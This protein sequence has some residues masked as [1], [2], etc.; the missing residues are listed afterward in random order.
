MS[1]FV[2]LEKR[3]LKGVNTL[4]FM[5]DRS[6]KGNYRHVVLRKETVANLK[7]RKQ[8]DFDSLNDVIA[9]L[10]EEGKEN[11][12]LTPTLNTEDLALLGELH[13]SLKQ[14]EASRKKSGRSGK[15]EADQARIVEKILAQ[16]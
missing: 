14:L 11:R 7:R 4:S 10:L 16:K 3:R 5:T 8:N 9:R 13:A 15:K 6:D 12:V 2:D 1:V